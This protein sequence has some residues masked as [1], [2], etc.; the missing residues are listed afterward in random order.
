MGETR[1][2]WERVGGVSQVRNGLQIVLSLGREVG[3]SIYRWGSKTSRFWLFC[4]KTGW[5]SPKT[6][7]TGFQKAVHSFLAD[8]TDWQKKWTIQKPAE[9]VLKPAEPVSTRLKTG[10]VIGWAGFLKPAEPVFEYQLNQY[11]PERNF[12]QDRLKKVV[13]HTLTKD[14]QG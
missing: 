4:T 7:W 12:S 9:L 10:W 11:F 13:L 1:D 14:Y 5:T 3:V 2:V 6:N 8:T